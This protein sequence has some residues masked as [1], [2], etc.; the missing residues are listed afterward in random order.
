MYRVLIESSNPKY[1][2]IM[3]EGITLDMVRETYR[4]QFGHSLREQTEDKLVMQRLANDPMECRCTTF[5]WVDI[6]ENERINLSMVDDLNY[7]FLWLKYQTNAQSFVDGMGW[8]WIR[9]GSDYVK[10]HLAIVSEG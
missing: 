3:N 6:P 7:T 2:M 9:D 5:Y 4:K 10:T 1:G 8:L